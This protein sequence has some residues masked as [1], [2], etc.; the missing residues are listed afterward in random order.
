MRQSSLGIVHTAEI[1]SHRQLA[2]TLLRN[3]LCHLE[4]LVGLHDQYV[5]HF[6]T[7]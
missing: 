1:A 5:L 3:A 7:F 2:M 4:G 6:V